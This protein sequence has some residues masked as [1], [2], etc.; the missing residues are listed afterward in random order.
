MLAW[1]P[2]RLIVSEGLNW[3][4]SGSSRRRIYPR[5]QTDDP[6]ERDGARDEP[7]RQREQ[8]PRRAALRLNVPVCPEVDN[9]ADHPAEHD[10]RDAAEDADRRR[11][12]EEDAADV[13]VAPTDGFHDAD[14]ARPLE[15][16][17]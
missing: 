4:E 2:L 10:A 14:F 9:P 15:N 7:Q 3:I 1:M 11:L 6:R 8:V 5:R 17:H 16:R 12:D 13:A